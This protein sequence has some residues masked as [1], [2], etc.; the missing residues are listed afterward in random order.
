M[1]ELCFDSIAHAGAPAPIL[2]VKSV[3]PLVDHV[4]KVSFSTGETKQID[5]KPLL[6]QPAFAPLVDEGLFNAVYVDYGCPVWDDGNIDIAPEYLYQHS[7][8]M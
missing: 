4:L 5:M 8:A 7:V 3:Q 2:K 1:P 6:S